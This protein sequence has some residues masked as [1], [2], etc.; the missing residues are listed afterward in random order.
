[1]TVIRGQAYKK[2]GRRRVWLSDINFFARPSALLSGCGGTR[3]SIKAWRDT[4]FIT[5]SVT[6]AARRHANNS[7][8]DCCPR[9]D[10]ILM[11]LPSRVSWAPHDPGELC[12]PS[13][14]GPE[15]LFQGQPS[16]PNLHLAH[17]VIR[18]T[19]LSAHWLITLFLCASKEKEMGLIFS[20]LFC[21]N[22]IRLWVPEALSEGNVNYHDPLAAFQQISGVFSTCGPLKGTIWWQ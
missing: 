6:S 12:T 8:A 3:N 16:P 10:A 2:C 13:R 5:G 4:T 21:G 18:L 15:S 20:H 17:S 9:V 22:F 1:M 19:F 7:L 14:A 11:W